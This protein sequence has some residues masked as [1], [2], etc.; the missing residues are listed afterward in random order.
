MLIDNFEVIIEYKNRAL[1]TVNKRKYTLSDYL[2]G[3]S[4]TLKRALMDVEIALGPRE[5]WT[6][7][8]SNAFQNIRSKLLDVSN[9]LVRLPENL[10]YSGE[11]CNETNVAKLLDK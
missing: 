5:Q 7:E 1:E 10:Y 3:N 9:A 6:E 8:V 4:T 2:H 11:R